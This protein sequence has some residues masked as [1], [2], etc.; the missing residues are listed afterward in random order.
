MVRKALEIKPDDGYIMDSLAW[1]LFKRGKSDDA[2]KFLEKAFIRV[3]SDPI[4][5]EHLGDVLTSKNRNQEAIE[6]YKKSMSLNPDN[7]LVQEKLKKL[8][9]ITGASSN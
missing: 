2:L 5:S 7:L 3:K 6:A 4:I 9:S 8:E 1:V